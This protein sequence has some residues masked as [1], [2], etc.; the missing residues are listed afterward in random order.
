MKNTAQSGQ[1]Q[2]GA[3]GAFEKKRGKGGGVPKFLIEDLKGY[4]DSLANAA[5][6]E[7]QT[8][9]ELVKSNATLTTRNAT[10]TPSI[11]ELQKKL[12]TIGRGTN[13]RKDPENQKR[14]CSNCKKEVFHSVDDCY[15]V[16]KNAHILPQ[17]W[18]SRV[19]RSGSSNVLDSNKDKGTSTPY[20]DL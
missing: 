17:V 11:V 10:L 16:E 20:S 6:T 9:A 8:L 18:K 1:D 5:T 14:T 13:T 3:H 15:K 2:F 19:L 7:K 12:G 4:F